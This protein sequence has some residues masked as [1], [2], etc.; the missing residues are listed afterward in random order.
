MDDSEDSDGV[1]G[2]ASAMS[3]GEAARRTKGADRRA[4][5]R[6]VL[7][8]GALDDLDEEFERQQIASGAAALQR[9]PPT[10]VKAASALSRA[11][12][13]PAAPRSR[14]APVPSALVLGGDADS[15]LDSLARSLSEALEDMN[16]VHTGHV[17]QLK[18]IKDDL[19]TS[20]ALVE[21]LQE[22]LEAAAER[23]K[24]R[25]IV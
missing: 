21:P 6:E 20:R 3:F 10:K 11:A 13:A 16:S 24:V 1:E 9:A 22:E 5:V 12:A 19:E 17:N 14:R 7:Q 2:S 8:D 15:T 25:A 18:R 4:R 23:Y